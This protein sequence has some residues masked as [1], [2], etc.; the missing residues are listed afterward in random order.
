MLVHACG[1]IALLGLIEVE[2]IAHCGWLLSLAWIA[3]R[4]VDADVCNGE[5]EVSSSQHSSLS[6]SQ[7]RMQCD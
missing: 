7:R 4:S 2:R 3:C 5:R 6:G 1:V